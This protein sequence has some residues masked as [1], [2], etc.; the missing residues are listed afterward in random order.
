MG[1]IESKHTGQRPP[2]TLGL[3]LAIL[4]SIMWFSILPIMQA[5]AILLLERRLRE[6]EQGLS[7]GNDLPAF[8]YGGE[9]RGVSDAVL[10]FQAATGCVFLVIGAAAWRGRP[11]SIR[12][13]MAFAVVTLTAVTLV[14][15]AA[16]L[17]QPSTIYEGIDSGAS[18]ATAFLNIRLILTVLIPLYVLW[19]MN[20]A[21]ARAF[22][23]GYYLPGAV[24]LR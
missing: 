15:T 24:A 7:L 13:I 1:V 5:G 23:R 4:V 20:R 18:I 3:S 2:R 8:A 22:Y 21:P 19:Y 14:T 10:W 16:A 9:F 6:A 12:W 11:R 17:N